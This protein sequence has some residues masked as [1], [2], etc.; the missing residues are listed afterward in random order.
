MPFTLYFGTAPAPANLT[1]ELIDRLVPVHFT[2]EQDAIH[3]AALVMRGGQHVWL[4]EGP[5]V[6]L[7]TGEIEERCRPILKVFRPKG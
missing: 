1:R 5:G 4:I 6:R 3:A 7:G 2:T